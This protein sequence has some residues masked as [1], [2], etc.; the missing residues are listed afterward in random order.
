M[1]PGFPEN[2]LIHSGQS[3][4]DAL[5]QTGGSLVGRGTWF[6]GQDQCWA[7]PLQFPVLWP[8]GAQG[9]RQQLALQGASG[10]SS[11][12]LHGSAFTQCVARQVSV[13]GLGR[14]FLHSARRQS[15]PGA[16]SQVLPPD[17][18]CAR[19]GWFSQ[20]QS[21]EGPGSMM[22]GLPGIGNRMWGGLACGGSES[23]G[24]TQAM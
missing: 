15:T 21:G 17:S 13:V 24:G 12:R 4:C 19:R 14:R 10:L 6:L 9:L 22:W 16:C 7:S 18:E 23:K 11:C 8:R 2:R 1:G 20:G 5:V 3:L